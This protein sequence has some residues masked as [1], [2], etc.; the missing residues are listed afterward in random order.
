MDSLCSAL[1]QA[2]LG[3]VEILREL[4]AATSLHNQALRQND[5][6]ALQEAMIQ[7]EEVTTR[8]RK[9]E[10]KRQQPYAALAGSLSL[11]EDTPLKEL[12]PYLPA[13]HR[14]KL[15]DLAAAI[16]NT[17]MEINGVVHLNSILTR[18]ALQFNAM[19]LD[20]LQPVHNSTYQPD[21]K[22]ASAVGRTALLNKT[23]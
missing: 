9:E 4:L 22:S 5:V 1:Y 11:P 12:L 2:L 6:A 23:V 7:E 8:L 10:Q 21:G 14:E 16:K 15:S 3:Q 17:A 19:L 20:A 18:Q 13:A